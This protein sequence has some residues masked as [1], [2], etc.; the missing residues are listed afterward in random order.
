MRCGEVHYRRLPYFDASLSA[1]LQQGGHL[2][3][4]TKVETFANLKQERNARGGA[5]VSRPRPPRESAR[6]DSQPAVAQSVERPA[7][8]PP[9]RPAIAAASCVLH[10]VCGRTRPAAAS[11]GAPTASP[12][13]ASRPRVC[14]RF[15]N[16]AVRAAR[17]AA[18]GRLCTPMCGFR[19]LS[20]SQNAAWSRAQ[21]TASGGGGRLARGR[22]G[23]VADGVSRLQIICRPSSSAD[24]LDVAAASAAGAPAR[25]A[26]EMVN[27]VEIASERPTE[28]LN[29]R[30]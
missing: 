13:R 9:Q 11:A 19:P 7:L 10:R 25:V 14:I 23:G 3:S 15:F 1:R 2:F 8:P 5:S 16:R 6:T 12:L 26:T 22:W 29:L 30:R 27:Y 20:L 17:P 18:G 21:R 24:H 4:S 28:R